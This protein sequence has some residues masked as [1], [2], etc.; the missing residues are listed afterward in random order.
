MLVQG[1]PLGRLSYLRLGLGRG[2]AAIVH[3]LGSSWGCGCRATAPHSGRCSRSL[4]GSL[5]L[6]HWAVRPG[7]ST[8]QSGCWA[9]LARGPYQTPALIR[10]DL[11]G[12]LCY[13]AGCSGQVGSSVCLCKWDLGRLS[14]SGLGLG[15]VAPT[16]VRGSWSSGGHG[17]RAAAAR[18]GR[19]SCSM[20]GSL[21]LYRLAV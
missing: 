7:Y 11:H 4:W 10:S 1:G 17:C 19:Y 18:P 20:W 8:R 21:L 9:L 12:H 3:D 14:Y 15:W 5:L 2:A 16:I 6:Y 13:F